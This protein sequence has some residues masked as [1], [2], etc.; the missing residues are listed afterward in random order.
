MNRGEP[1]NSGPGLLSCCSGQ[2]GLSVSDLLENL[3]L[4]K[5][6][7]QI[8]SWGIPELPESVS[9]MF[10]AARVSGL[11]NGGEAVFILQCICLL[12]MAGLS[13]HDRIRKSTGFPGPSSAH[14]AI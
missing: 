7:T 12:S 8:F 9:E 13:V 3:S 11:K 14:T 6:V 2:G 1:L 5:S 10:V 4:C